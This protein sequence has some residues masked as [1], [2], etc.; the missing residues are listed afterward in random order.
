MNIAV[1]PAR[2]GSKR[3]PRK[4]IRSFCGV[5]LLSRTVSLLSDIPIFDRVVVS[6]DDDEVA[7]VAERAGAELPFRRPSALADDFAPTRAVMTHAVG[8]LSR[9]HGPELRYVCCVYPAATMTTDEDY[10]RALALLS[11]DEAEYVFAGAA[12]PHPIERAYRFDERGRCRMIRPE[13]ACSR[14]QDLEP[15]FH[16][17]GQFY[18]APVEVWMDPDRPSFRHMIVLPRCRV[19]DIDTLEDWEMAERLFATQSWPHRDTDDQ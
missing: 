13:H 12:Y 1:I 14:S 7:A 5:P 11:E 3:I 4:N 16:D 2:G 19:I 6:T 9:I 17:A 8:E 15:A 18:F 10:R